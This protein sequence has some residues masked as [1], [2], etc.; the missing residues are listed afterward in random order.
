MVFPALRSASAG[1]RRNRAVRSQL[2]QPRRRRARD[3]LLHATTMSKSSSARFPNSKR[4]SSRSGISSSSTGFRLPTKSSICVSDAHP[5]SLKQWK[6]TP[7]DLESRR[8]WED[9]T[10]AKEAML[11]RPTFPRRPGGSC[12]PTTRS[13]PGSTAFITCLSQIPYQEV[14]R[15]PVA[16]PARVHNPDYI[17]RRCRKTSTC[18]RSTEAAGLHGT[19]QRKRSFPSGSGG[20]R[21]GRPYVFSFDFV[22]RRNRCFHPWRLPLLPMRRCRRASDPTPIFRHRNPVSCRR[23]RSRPV[24]AGRRVRSPTPADL[25][26]T[27]Y[28]PGLDHPRWLYVLPNG[29]VLVAETNG[30][31]RPDD[32]KGIKAWFQKLFQK[33]AGAQAQSA[34]RITLLRG[35]EA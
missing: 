2:V 20:R 24:S 8:R 22:H 21:P 27:A 15:T 7:M 23:S 12:T 19:F 31:K 14:P 5:R 16:L 9:Y 30:P 28:A 3:G 35:D 18:R 13:A 4:C 26:V 6:L 34:D 17:A 29:D 11:E 25:S 1:G 10:K 33:Y 32:G